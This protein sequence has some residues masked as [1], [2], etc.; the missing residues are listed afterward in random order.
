MLKQLNNYRN[1]YDDDESF[2]SL[3]DLF[4]LIS[5]SLILAT[6]IFGLKSNASLNTVHIPIKEIIEQAGSTDISL[7]QVMIIYITY[8]GQHDKIVIRD[9]ERGKRE[10]TVTR[11][12]VG[13]ILNDELSYVANAREV[14]LIL[15]RKG[16]DS[17]YAIFSEVQ[18]WMSTKGMSDKSSVG[19]TK[20]K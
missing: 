9:S 1:S 8:E 4:T 13:D 10:S 18:D 2:E 20:E 14:A 7:D 19:F 15:N 3:V 16:S 6:L 17:T 5:I 11:K 12:T